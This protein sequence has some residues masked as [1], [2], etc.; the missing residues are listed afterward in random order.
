MALVHQASAQ[1]QAQDTALV[2]GEQTWAL[3]VLYNLS[4]SLKSLLLFA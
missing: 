4:L 1:R 3:V 2:V